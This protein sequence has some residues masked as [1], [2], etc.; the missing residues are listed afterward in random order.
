MLFLAL[1]GCFG[2]SKV[3]VDTRPTGATLEWKETVATSPGT[4]TVPFYPFA[5]RKVQVS[6]PGYR[7]VTVILRR[8]DHQIEVVLVPEH[9][10]V[11]TWTPEGQGLSP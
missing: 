3:T 5:R 2:H 6:S 1:I 9:G 10:P 7:P 11:G 4:V 8:K